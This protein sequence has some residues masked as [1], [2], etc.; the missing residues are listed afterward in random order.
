MSVTLTLNGV[1]WVIPT[2]KNV[3]WGTNVTG[4]LQDIAEVLDGTF[5][6]VTA[7]GASTFIDF[8]NGKNIR[9]LLNASTTLTLLHPR[10]G[11]PAYFYVKQ[12]GA[13]SLTFPS[14]TWLH[15]AGGLVM[16]SVSSGKLGVAALMYE[17]IDNVY[18]GEYGTQP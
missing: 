6:T 10:A 3:H 12:A 11:R 18:V 2:V 8:D 17:P 4:Y 9:L 16:S 7:S 15:S 1:Q 14:V 13:F 5:Q